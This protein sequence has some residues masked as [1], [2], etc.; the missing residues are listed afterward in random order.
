MN[1]NLKKYSFN[2][3]LEMSKV[4]IPKIQRDYAQ[5]RQ[6]KKVDEIRKTFVHSLILVVKGRKPSAELDF[7][8]GSNQDNAFEPLDGQQRL[9]TL[10]LL[11][12]ML[13]AQLHSPKN[14]KQSLFTYETRNTSNEF[15]NE[16]VQHDATIFV[17]EAQ[18]NRQYN[19]T[20]EK[21]EDKKPQTPSAIIKRRDWFKWEWN[22]DPTI[23][24]ML[25]MIDAID[26]ELG[27]D[28]E[29]NR[30]TY[31]KNLDNITFNLL[32]LLDFNLS[33]ELFIKMNARGK[34]LSEFDK[35]KSTLEEE[36][37]IQQNETDEDGRPL[38]TDKDEEDWRSL[39]DGI[40]IDLFWHKYAR[41]Q[42]IDTETIPREERKKKRLE[43][44]ELSEYQFKKLL[45]R[46]I[47]L[48]LLENDPDNM[49]LREAAYAINYDSIDNLMYTYTDCLTDIRSDERH[50]ALSSSY[51]T[52]DFRRLIEDFNL[53]VYKDING[54]YHEI[55]YLLPSKC[56]I[57]PNDDRS[58]FDLF[59][60]NKVPNDVELIFYSMLL[61]LRNF[62]AKKD[63]DWY[64]DRD[65]HLS[66]LKNLE[67]WV[68]ILRNIL[69][70]D[71]NNQ[72]IDKISL[73]LEALKSIK[74]M[75][76]DFVSF[77]KERGLDLENDATAVRQ[78]LLSSR[79]TYPRLDNMSLNEERNKAEYSLDNPE[80]ESCINKAEQHPYLWGQVRC[81]LNWSDGN[82]D[83]FK[84][85]STRLTSLLDFIEN[86]ELAYY[87]AILAF[88][89]KCWQDG[90][91]LFQYNKDRDNS[92]KRYLREHSKEGQSYG[93]HIKALIDLWK[94]YYPS[95]SVGE[96]LQHV[97][98]DR[99]ETSAPWIRCIIDDPSILNLSWNKRIYSHKG[100]PILA[101]RKTMDSHCFDPLFAY[102][103]NLCISRKYPNTEFMLYDSKGEYEHAFC[104]NKGSHNYLVEWVGSEGQ[105]SIS[106]DDN[107]PTEHTPEQM[108]DIMEALITQY[109]S[110]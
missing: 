87:S 21:E 63:D 103:Y 97:T 57:E 75:A 93:A 17:S 101:Q 24:S 30:S 77:V 31:N 49:S 18:T 25:V 74:A 43:S 79:K 23:Q 64:F 16:L 7:V 6:N 65:R 39:M 32:N 61:F 69:L 94:G 33:N 73:T 92:F 22:Y 26:E 76:N 58:L 19:K 81:L 28:W 95:D 85:Y 3:L 14:K 89:P 46:L 53:L 41:Q 42:I 60:E 72:R 78:F 82:L 109:P 8:Y 99:R 34:Q 59:L 9:T 102:L 90:N 52:I 4:R 37:Q 96:F 40:W 2:S 1:E 105:Y 56:H 98:E 44:A 107:V 35:L 20:T 13:G 71:N 10:F 66:W 48:Q 5:G 51:T 12:W 106:V 104:L 36:M 86:D 45:L 100:H 47:A 83:A 15:C 70:N 11:H 84:D 38:A 80:W 55:S 108:L 68:R 62:P 54:I 29:S 88:A 67:E 110:T 91:R 27:N 50:T